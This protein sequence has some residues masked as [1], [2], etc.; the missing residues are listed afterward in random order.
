MPRFIVQSQHYHDSNKKKKQQI[1]QFLN[2]QFLNPHFSK[3]DIQMA[4][5]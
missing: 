2:G 4:I 1:I 3:E 5:R